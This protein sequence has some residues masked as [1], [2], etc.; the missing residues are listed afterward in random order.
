VL[1]LKLISIN[2]LGNKHEA[3]KTIITYDTMIPLYNQRLIKSTLT[4]LQLFRKWAAGHRLIPSLVRQAEANLDR[5]A[6]RQN[7]C[8]AFDISQAAL[9]KDIAAE[10]S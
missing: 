1:I 7:F 10:V 2:D 4:K 8:G 9:P 6:K 3:K 5:P